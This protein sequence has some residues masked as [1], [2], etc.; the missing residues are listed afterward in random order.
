MWKV[1][2]K[3]LL[4]TDILIDVGDNPN[5]K[6]RHFN[7]PV[8]HSN[9]NLCKTRQDSPILGNDRRLR[10]ELWVIM[11]KRD[12]A[13]RHVGENVVFSVD[14]TVVFNLTLIVCTFHAKS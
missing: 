1:D 2:Q 12:N 3:E 5:R 6:F 10:I 8:L 9:E 7:L 11:L 13:N 14:T 4:K